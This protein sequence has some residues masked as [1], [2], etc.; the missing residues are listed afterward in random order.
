[1]GQIHI[2]Q[3]VVPTTDTTLTITSGTL[4]GQPQAAEFW[5]ARSTAN[6]TVSTHSMIAVGATDGTRQFNVVNGAE[7]AQTTSDT[8]RGAG[9]VSCGFFLDIGANGTD[10]VLQFDNWVEG[11]V[12]LSI[13]SADVF[14]SAWRIGAIF[15]QGFDNIRV[16]RLVA[17][18]VA[19]GELSVSCGFQPNLVKLYGPATLSE[20]NSGHGRLTVGFALDNGA[21]EHHHVAT[22]SRT[23]TIG[24][25]V[26]AHYGTSVTHSHFANNITL[27]GNGEVSSFGSD[28]FGYTTNDDDGGALDI[29]YIAIDSGSQEVSLNTMS[30]PGDG[31]TGVVAYTGPGF[32]PV[33]V[34]LVSSRMLAVDTT[35]T[36]GRAGNLGLHCF[37]STDAI[38]IAQSDQDAAS[39]SVAKN[40]ASQ[41][42]VSA[43]SGTGTS[44]MV[45]AFSS[46]D[47]NGYSI[48]WTSTPS[49]GA[50]QWIE[51]AFAQEAVSSGTA[52]RRSNHILLGV[53]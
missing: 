47:S 23:S 53:G 7:D 1:M 16:D 51:L 25:Q 35:Y 14:S 49:D 9:S 48:N 4:T 21:I 6:D 22:A 38:S 34:Q 42:A 26:G 43:L 46:F 36:D 44:E 19:A 33:A 27:E 2:A 18:T 29:Y 3:S 30:P 52:R 12:Q 39:P 11:G 37:N 24:A 31:S 41:N 15:Y 40:I 5:L 8:S 13:L 20:A 45:G 17:P 32:E 50:Q 28:G 10:G